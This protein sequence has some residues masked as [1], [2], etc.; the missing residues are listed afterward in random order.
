MVTASY[1]SPAMAALEGEAQA[2]GVCLLNEM[3]L[4]PGLD[5]LSAMRIIDAARSQ[6]DQVSLGGALF[7]LLGGGLY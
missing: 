5:H 3:G 1:I 2:K 4:D 6:G 7:L